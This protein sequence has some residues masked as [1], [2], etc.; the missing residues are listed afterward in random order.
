[1]IIEIMFNTYGIG[2]DDSFRS[3]Y[4]GWGMY[5]KTCV[6]FVIQAHELV[7]L[8]AAITRAFKDVDEREPEY[9]ADVRMLART[10]HDSMGLDVIVYFPDV[11]LE[12]DK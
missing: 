9:G 8:G 2:G 12:E 4:S 11:E 10:R 7:A 5:G 6:G 1:M 3:N